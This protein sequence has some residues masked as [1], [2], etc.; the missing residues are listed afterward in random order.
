MRRRQYTDAPRAL[1]SKRA[2][3]IR[4]DEGM[5]KDKNLGKL[6]SRFEVQGGIVNEFDFHLN[7]GALTE[8]E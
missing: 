4:E 7:K 3:E 8:E 2:G 5:A 1:S 6:K